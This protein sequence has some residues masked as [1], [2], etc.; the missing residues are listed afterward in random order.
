MVCWVAV[1]VLGLEDIRYNG[2]NGSGVVFW[3]FLGLGLGLRLGA[4]DGRLVDTPY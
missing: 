1:R 2:D 3:R 4:S